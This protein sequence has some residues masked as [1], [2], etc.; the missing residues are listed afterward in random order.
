MYLYN[1]INKLN[2]KKHKIIKINVSTDLNIKNITFF[3]NKYPQLSSGRKNYMSKEI[4]IAK[5]KCLAKLYIQAK[6]VGAKSIDNI[7]F[8]QKDYKIFA[9]ANFIF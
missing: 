7:H 5:N 9:Y 2:K 4:N 1:S 6:K 8:I 3:L